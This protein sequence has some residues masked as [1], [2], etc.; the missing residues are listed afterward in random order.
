MS[1][2]EMAEQNGEPLLPE[3]KYEPRTP[4]H[5][6]SPVKKHSP[7]WRRESRKPDRTEADGNLLRLSPE[8]AK[9]HE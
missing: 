2:S 6:S 3:H 9:E 8:I 7:L 5:A 4:L 1:L